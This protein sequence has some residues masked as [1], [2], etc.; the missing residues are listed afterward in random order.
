MIHIATT[1][2]DANDSTQFNVTYTTLKITTN[3]ANNPQ[4]L[5]NDLNIT[6]ATND[7]N[8]VKQINVTT[9][10]DAN[11]INIDTT[12][13]DATNLNTITDTANDVNDDLKKKKNTTA[14]ND[15]TN[16]KITLVT[17]NDV[18]NHLKKKKNTTATNDATNL[19]ITIDTTNDVN[20]LKFLSNPNGWGKIT[21]DILGSFQVDFTANHLQ[22][23]FT[24][25]ITADDVDYKLRRDQL[26]VRF[27]MAFYMASAEVGETIHKGVE[28]N[29]G[30][31]TKGTME[32][33]DK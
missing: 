28:L 31:Y 32:A 3:D 21:S 15:A 1:T 17:T 2:N 30:T 25:K 19:K 24:G 18:N 27:Y 33:D 7:V 5:K 8:D 23:Y 4:Y 12:T 29:S 11:N 6:T 26:M 9:T 13:N 14:A 16:L 22:V 10:K 20:K